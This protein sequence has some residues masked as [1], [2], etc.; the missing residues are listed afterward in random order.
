LSEWD[1][2]LVQ[3]IVGAVLYAV[4]IV[5][6]RESFR[7]MLRVAW[8]EYALYAVVFGSV[9]GAFILL[10]MEPWALVGAILAVVAVTALTLVIQE[11]AAAEKRIP[12]W[13]G[14]DAPALL[15]SLPRDERNNSRVLHRM[16]SLLRSRAAGAVTENVQ[17]TVDLNDVDW[18]RGV[19]LYDVSDV[20]TYAL[21]ETREIELVIEVNPDIIGHGRAHQD[22]RPLP[23]SL[24]DPAGKWR[25]E[26]GPLI[27]RE[28]IPAWKDLLENVAIE[29]WLGHH[30]RRERT[31]IEFRRERV[32]HETFFGAERVVSP[33]VRFSSKIRLGPENPMITT[34]VTAM[35]QTVEVPTLYFFAWD[36]CTTAWKFRVDAERARGRIHI[37]HLEP[38]TTSE[39]VVVS[40]WQVSDTHGEITLQPSAG[41]A[42]LPQDAALLHLR[43]RRPQGG[44]KEK[45][46]RGT[47]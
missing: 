27:R 11:K 36:V 4:A 16:A 43:L 19:F 29:G 2:L 24:R 35:P 20:T 23:V 10:G 13:L 39:D 9:L 30:A 17:T 47:S 15:H 14:P 34:R 26:F 31:R 8:A 41:S 1:D 3:G 28:D 40:S 44:V 33:A 42:I 46:A 45:A 6:M 5:L 22:F 12:E 37:A 38:I 7:R 18:R 32:D 21:D 25:T